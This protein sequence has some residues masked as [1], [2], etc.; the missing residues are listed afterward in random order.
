MK[1]PWSDIPKPSYDSNVLRLDIHHPLKLF[2]GLDEQ[3]KRLFIIDA[4]YEALPRP[5]EIPHLTGIEIWTTTHDE[6]GKIVF[7]L[8]DTANG[9]LF[10]SLCLDLINVSE[11]AETEEIAVQKIM[12][13]LA[14]W[15]EFLRTERTGILTKQEILG[16]IGELL[17]LKE[18]LAPRFG[19]DAAVEFWKGPE[20]APQDFAVHETAVEIKCQGGASK[21][22]VQINSVDQL[23]PQLP[24]GYLVVQTIATSAH[25]TKGAMTLNSLIQEIRNVLKEF[26][27]EALERFEGLILQAGYIANEHYDS[28]TFKLVD[29]TAFRLSPGFPRISPENIPHGITDVSYQLNLDAC[30]PFTCKITF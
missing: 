17:F 13:R 9:E 6:R 19:W 30:A 15:Q 4:A 22:S 21:R 18:T 29:S 3:S 23:C 5:K 11:R 16:L 12:R 10:H 20:G 27:H 7:R 28:F 1:N 8:K 14:R 25:Q 24:Q 26:T 2:W